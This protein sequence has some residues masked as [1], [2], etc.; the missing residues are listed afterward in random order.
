MSRF[1]ASSLRFD[2]LLSHLLPTPT[3]RPGEW[4][5]R[6]DSAYKNKRYRACIDMLNKAIH[7]SEHQP[8]DRQFDCRAAIRLR[9]CAQRALGNYRYAVADFQQLV[10][11]GPL[12]PD[13]YLDLACL[14][15]VYDKPAAAAAVLSAGI[16]RMDQRRA[17]PLFLERGKIAARNKEYLS[18]IDDLNIAIYYLSDLAE[19]WYQRGLLKADIRAFRPAIRDGRMATLV[20][21]GSHAAHYAYARILCRA[22]RYREALSPLSRTIE[23]APDHHA[24]V[25]LLGRILVLLKRREEARI[26]LD[27]AIEM[28]ATDPGTIQAHQRAYARKKFKQT[29]NTPIDVPGFRMVA[30]PYFE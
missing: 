17:A 23:L 26:F 9:G 8:S 5:R 7:L 24:P 3:L 12:N 6:A 22:G 15:C 30:G 16:Q 20:D 11:Q 2:V 28:G 4:H 29:G 10:D 27:K 14:H 25:S 18:A 21:P 13:N 1:D 19:G